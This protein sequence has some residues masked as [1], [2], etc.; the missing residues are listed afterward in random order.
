MANDEDSHSVKEIENFKRKTMEGAGVKGGQAEVVEIDGD[1]VGVDPLT[2]KDKKKI[3][4]AGKDKKKK[5]KKTKSDSDDDEKEI[6]RKE[7][8]T[9]DRQPKSN[10]KI[11]GGG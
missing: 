9:A 7:D 2:K 1:I 8:L 11:I 10:Q 4:F 3:L 6:M 5:K